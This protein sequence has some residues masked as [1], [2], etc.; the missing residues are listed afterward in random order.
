ME[1]NLKLIFCRRDLYFGIEQYGG[2]FTVTANPESKRERSPSPVPINTDQAVSK[3]D[4]QHHATKKFIVSAP[5]SNP[6]DSPVHKSLQRSTSLPTKLAAFVIGKKSSVPSRKTAS[7][8]LP[9]VKR[10]TQST[11]TVLPPGVRMEIRTEE[12]KSSSSHPLEISPSDT[13]HNIPVVSNK[14]SL[15]QTIIDFFTSVYFYPIL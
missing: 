6:P 10:R 3:A 9:A 13:T 14:M 15:A 1:V 8:R 5:R 11:Q 2:P 4:D 12:K 7:P